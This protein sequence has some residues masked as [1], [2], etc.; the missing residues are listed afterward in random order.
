MNCG[1][2]IYRTYA[3]GTAR[4]PPYSTK[5]LL[6]RDVPRG[7][8]LVTVIDCVKHCSSFYEK[9]SMSS[10]SN[11]SLKQLTGVESCQCRKGRIQRNHIACA[12]LVWL[13]L[14]DLARYTDQT[15]YQIKH[16]LL[17]NPPRSA[18]KTSGCSHAY[19]LVVGREA[20]LSRAIACDSCVSPDLF[21]FQGSVFVN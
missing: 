18:T 14:K 4:S 17:S 20:R 5:I 19:P 16:G 9:I 10:A 8:K 21:Y 12:I 1:A 2:I 11:K 3:T 7:V 15:I 13:R 6:R